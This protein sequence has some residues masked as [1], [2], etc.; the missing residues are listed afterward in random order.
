MMIGNVVIQDNA[1]M[2]DNAVMQDDVVKFGD[3]LIALVIGNTIVHFMVTSL[4]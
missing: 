1:V 4:S 3:V 2:L